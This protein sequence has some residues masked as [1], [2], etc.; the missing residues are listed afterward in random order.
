MLTHNQV[1]SQQRWNTTVGPWTDE[2]Q[3]KTALEWRIANTS[4]LVQD[5][6]PRRH[7]EER[8]VPT[9]RGRD[10]GHCWGP[11]DNETS[12]GALKRSGL[13]DETVGDLVDEIDAEVT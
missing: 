9:Q 11:Q 1:L 10:R 6:T 13:D 7:G 5:C 3:V 12:T 8:V 4:W 2:H